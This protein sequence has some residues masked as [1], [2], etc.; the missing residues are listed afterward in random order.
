MKDILTGIAAFIGILVV[1]IVTSY[2]FGWIGVHQKST[3][4]AAME[5]ADRKVFENSQS[6][7]EGKRQEAIKLYREYK[8]DIDSRPAL[9]EVAVHQFANFDID[10]L[11]SPSKQFIANCF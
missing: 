8:K 3:I 5:D 7:V 10:K 1:V 6:Y 9:C 11:H 4:G 2:M